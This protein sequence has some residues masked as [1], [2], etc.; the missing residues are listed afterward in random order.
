MIGVNILHAFLDLLDVSSA[1]GEIQ[2]SAVFPK[3][4]STQVNLKSK[5]LAKAV[6]IVIFTTVYEHVIKREFKAIREKEA[7]IDPKDPFY[8]K[9]K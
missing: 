1:D 9:M 4:A 5:D 8:K 3:I 7:S 2:F 6:K